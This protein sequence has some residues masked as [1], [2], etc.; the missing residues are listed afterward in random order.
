MG[1]PLELITENCFSPIPF[2]WFI[3]R[4]TELKF[5]HLFKLYRCYGSKNGRQNRLKTEIF[6]KN[7]IS[8]QLNTK[9]LLICCVPW[10]LSSSVKIFFWY[11]LVLYLFSSVKPL[12]FAPKWSISYF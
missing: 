6:F 11:L 5:R 10:Y 1:L 8:A 4:K 2:D 3:R 9:N 12:N 7:Y